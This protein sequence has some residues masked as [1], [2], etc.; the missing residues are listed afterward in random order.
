MMLPEDR[1]QYDPAFRVLVD[2]LEIQLRQADYTP[3]ELRAAVILAAIHY[4]E[5]NI[6]KYYVR[7]D[8]HAAIEEIMWDVQRSRHDSID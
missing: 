5:T 6:R 1:Y 2:A 8:E 3:S 7:R 4:E